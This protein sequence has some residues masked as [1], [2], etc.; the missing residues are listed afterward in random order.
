MEGEPRNPYRMTTIVLL[1]A[2]ICLGAVIL[3]G[4]LECRNAHD[5]RR[6]LGSLGVEGSKYAAPE[7]ATTET[8]TFD[9]VNHK[10]SGYIII[11][12]GSEIGM[13]HWDADKDQ[14]LTGFDYLFTGSPTDPNCAEFP[15]PKGTT[16]SDFAATGEA[17]IATGKYVACELTITTHDTPAVT[18]NVHVIILGN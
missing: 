11:C 18:Q 7:C 17:T 15:H 12:N 16:T 9:N 5:S 3:F 14:S 1:V 2:V 4:S 10:L 8:A 13:H 6:I